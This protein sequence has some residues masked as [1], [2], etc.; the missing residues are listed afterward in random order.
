MNKISTLAEL[1]A[2]KQ[3]LV[4]NKIFLETEI[5][6]EF[7]ELK[8]DLAPLK[9][10]TQGAGKV[11][12]S[13]QNKILGNSAGHLA[14]LLAKNVFLRHSGFITRIIVPFLAKNTTSNFVEDN[15]SKIAGWIM[16]QVERF[17]NKKTV[18]A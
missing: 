15:K 4:M 13:D 8:N 18:K 14:E 11:L 1:K 6:K 16:K 9:I 5:K 17:S 3:L 7:N 10:L 2:E 12:S